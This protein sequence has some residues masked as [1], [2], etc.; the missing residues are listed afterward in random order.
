[1][2][3]FITLTN[4]QYPISDYD[5]PKQLVQAPLA[6][7][8]LLIVSEVAE[9]FEQL[10][11]HTNLE[12]DIVI[13]DAYRSKATQQQL[14]QE[15]LRDKGELFTNRYVARP[16]CSEHELG[17]AIDVG[18]SKKNNDF[19]RPSFID[20][21]IVDCFLE[22]MTDFGFILRYPKNKETIT[23][24]SFEPWHF[25]YVGTPHS[26]IMTQQ[27]W[28]L[29]EYIEFLVSTRGEVNEY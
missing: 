13:V 27:D 25:R 20:S 15:T 11:K 17:L 28:V 8:G 3:Q 26:Q 2:N 16:G 1:M 23:N 12:N 5:R 19:I 10:V 29:E 4:R 14:W 22:N 7:K 6:K 18:L 24:I 21:P 9:K